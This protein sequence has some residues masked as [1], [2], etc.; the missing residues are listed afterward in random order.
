MQ[1]V[2]LKAGRAEAFLLFS[3]P[4][5]CS[6]VP[7]GRNGI[8]FK[9]KVNTSNPVGIW[10]RQFQWVKR[11]NYDLHIGLKFY[12]SWKLYKLVKF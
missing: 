9:N 4:S 8:A 6:F 7:P 10:K 5:Q 1:W 11:V 3:F 12:K 2:A